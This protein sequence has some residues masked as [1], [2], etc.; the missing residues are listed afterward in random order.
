MK[1]TKI[2]SWNVNGIRSIAKK[3]FFKDFK[4]LSPDILCLQETKAGVDDVFASP[5]T[6][7]NTLI[8]E[9][10]PTLERPMKAISG[11]SVFGHWST[12]ALLLANDADWIFIHKNT[13]RI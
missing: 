8:S 12:F 10:F 2:I 13:T 7:H 6:P 5:F 9:D 4:L 11:N 1:Q 3:D